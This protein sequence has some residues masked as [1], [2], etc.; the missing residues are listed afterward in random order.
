MALISLINSF[1]VALLIP[2]SINLLTEE[3]KESCVI[4]HPQFQISW[5]EK[6]EKANEIPCMMH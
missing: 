1:F 4:L 2:F 3:T 6:E 5:I